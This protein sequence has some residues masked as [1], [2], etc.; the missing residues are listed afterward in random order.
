MHRVKYAQQPASLPSN[1]VAV[2]DALLRLNPVNGQGLAKSALEAIALDGRLRHARANCS[3]LP[4][5]FGAKYFARVAQITDGTWY[6]SLL[7]RIYWYSLLSRDNGKMDDYGNESCTPAKGESLELGAGYRWFSG[8]VLR[9][10]LRGV[11]TR[12]FLA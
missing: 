4:T 2:G 5:D 12:P 6:D 10:V 11:C 9:R 3:V 1:F 7:A 8:I